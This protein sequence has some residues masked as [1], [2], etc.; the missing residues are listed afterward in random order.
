[1]KNKVFKIVTVL[2]FFLT[3]VD[4]LFISTLSAQ[5]DPPTKVFN[6][7]HGAT[8]R[9]M[10]WMEYTDAHNSLYHHFKDL[11]QQN[12]N[13]R[14]E[15]IQE[16]KTEA[17][18][19][20]RQAE[21]HEKLLRVLGPFPEKTDLNAK[22]IEV[23]EQPGY[24]IEKVLFE[25]IPGFHVTACL[26]I[27]EEL[28]GKAPA[29]L[30][31]SGHT[32]DAFRTRKYQNV[33][34]NLVNKGFIVLAFDPIGQ[35]ERIQYYD[36]KIG[37]SRIGQNT[38][39]H[40][41]AG[42]QCFI[43][44]GSIARYFAWD[45]IRAID[46]LVSRPEVDAERIGCHGNSGGGLQTALISAIDQRVKAAAPS[47]YITSFRWLLKSQGV[48]DGEQNFYHFW[49]EGLDIPDFIEVRAPLP[50]LIMATTRD[51]FPIRGAREAYKEALMP[52]R[53]FGHEDHLQ[54]VVDDDLH[55]YTLKTR[56]AM[57]A[58]FQK[59][60][61]HRGSPVEQEVDYLN[62]QE[63]AV[64]PTGQV[65]T[66]FEGETVFSIN[67]K[68]TQILLERLEQSRKDPKV[69]LEKVKKFSKQLSGCQERVIQPTDAVLTGRYDS[70]PIIEKLFI[71]GSG[72]YPVPFLLMIPKQVKK[73][74]VVLF[75][76][77]LGKDIKEY[78]RA[79][80]P[81]HTL[82]TSGY[83][84]LVPDLINTGEV[85]PTEFRGD[86]TIDTIHTSNIWY[87]GIQNAKSI[88]GLR[89]SDVNRLVRY[90]QT[91]FPGRPVAGVS[92]GHYNTVLLH[93]AATNER[94]EL[95]GMLDPLISYESLV[96]NKYYDIHLLY[97][98]PGGGLRDYDLPDLAACIAPRKILMLNATDQ[99]GHFVKKGSFTNTY[100]FTC[101]FYESKG[102]LDNL[103]IDT[104]D[105]EDQ[106]GEIL[107]GWLE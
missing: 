33:I 69:H 51:F 9:R 83:V 84:V 4:L 26:F 53:L 44:G 41:Y 7:Y 66:S 104:T 88:V 99:N 20:K 10:V 97:S 79:Y 56:E 76:N 78:E 45:G 18:W 30:Y 2:I 105:D 91:R 71:Q 48:A 57:Y 49:A 19:K 54:I 80:S 59:H 92:N 16:L 107:A 28:K 106:A 90:I 23:L 25:S 81:L 62:G 50:M 29:V 98:A 72:N 52:Y 3:L 70:D 87:M 64:T 63:L 5:Y 42:N 15:V 32:V 37:E 1:M 74:T 96:M 13:K 68:E 89:A 75:L 73:Q 60:L 85:G 82:L 55:G 38:V 24:T 11:G 21:V 67:R 31:C 65:S 93:A 61:N 22:V 17:D 35:G 43:S 6:P 86:A 27:P 40:S 101:D 77:P 36:S 103:R 12:L 34:L 58:F 47:G 8:N 46:Y 39:T 102:A 95:V 14:L 100:S 94:I